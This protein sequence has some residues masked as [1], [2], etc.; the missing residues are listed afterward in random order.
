MS[1]FVDVDNQNLLWR[2]SHKIPE[3]QNIPSSQKDTFFKQTIQQV[4]DTISK[5]ELT[6]EELQ[7]YNQN[8]LSH[9]VRQLRPP[10]PPITKPSNVLPQP[11]NQSSS[12]FVESKDELFQ[13]QFQAK[14][15][16]YE[17]MNAK[18]DIPDAAELFKEKIEDDER[19]ENMDELLKQYESQREQ[20]M[21]E[22]MSKTIPPSTAISENET[23]PE[24]LVK[25]E[26]SKNTLS[27]NTKSK[28]FS[29]PEKNEKLQYFLDNYDLFIGIFDKIE[30]LN[31]RL[32]L[33]ESSPVVEELSSSSPES[34]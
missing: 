33:L 10:V 18:P 26:P 25:K 19:I 31:R 12:F 27:E 14:Q 21:K 24:V 13:R 1:Q 6:R 20:D 17:S 16:E 3:F 29:N 32:V 22:V 23:N 28:H 7:T 34:K 4:Y 30:D 9:I 2:M 5:P 8:V 11:Q 15:Q